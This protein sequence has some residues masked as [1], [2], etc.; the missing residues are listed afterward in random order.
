MR[1]WRMSFRAGN[2]GYEMWPECLRLGV[3]AITYYPL[4]KIDLS[5]Y[6]EG[7]PKNLWNELEPTQKASLGRVA[8]KMKGGD[9]IYVKKGPKIVDKGIVEGAI[10]R[11]AY[12][13]DT[14]FR[15]LDPNGVP[16]AHQ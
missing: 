15:L 4:A 5:K 14:K 6:P 16:W 7:E 11:N 13:F 10:G 1:T 12:K 9:I 8:Y 2:Q 3:A